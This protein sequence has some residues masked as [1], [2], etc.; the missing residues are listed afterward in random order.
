MDA[1]A[2]I[3]GTAPVEDETLVDRADTV[4]R[5]VAISSTIRR[6]VALWEA[7]FCVATYYGYSSLAHLVAPSG[8]L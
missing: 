1:P 5:R 2:H 3:T 6:L 8:T 7:R 4:Q